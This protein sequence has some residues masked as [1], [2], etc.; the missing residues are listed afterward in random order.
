MRNDPARPGTELLAA[1]IAVSRGASADQY[2]KTFRRL[3]EGLADGREREWLHC[4]TGKPIF[5]Q[6]INDRA[7][8]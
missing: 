3:F 1:A 4:H 8:S 7:G 6:G 5:C 2:L